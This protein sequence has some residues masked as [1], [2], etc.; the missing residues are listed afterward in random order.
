MDETAAN[1]GESK[2]DD[3][4]EPDVYRA[5]R[6]IAALAE[7]V[8]RAAWPFFALAG[9]DIVVLVVA[10]TG[11]LGLAS[12]RPLASAI[13]WALLPAAV[14]VGCPDAWR[15]ARGIFLGVVAWSTVPVVASLLLTWPRILGVETSDA[16][17]QSSSLLA[18][19][20]EIAGPAIVAVYLERRRRTR[21][22]WPAAVVAVAIVGVAVACAYQASTALDWLNNRQLAPQ[23][24]GAGW[25]DL[26]GLV[27]VVSDTAGPVVLLSVGALA[28]SSLA[29]VRGFETRRRFWLALTV[30][31]ACLLTADFVGFAVWPVVG[32]IGYS[33]QLDSLV[34]TL[35]DLEVWA[36][37]AG[38]G[39]VLLAFVTGLPAES[40]DP[41]EAVA[42]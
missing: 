9:L 6:Q 10:G 1:G 23:L 39:L 5:A 32:A 24:D 18:L 42:A 29:A 35:S 30:G 31:A 17:Q 20:A 37:L 34:W 7:R 14:V 26:A 33:P 22:S 36:G 19:I 38:V 25:V 4:P 41:V 2:L 27:R 15:S 21:T 16:G 3:V 28:W 13:C 12:L 8:P 11:G 40:R